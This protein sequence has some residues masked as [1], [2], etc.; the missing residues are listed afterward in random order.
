MFIPNRTQYML[1]VVNIQLFDC[2]FKMNNL[3]NL[4]EGLPISHIVYHLHNVGLKRTYEAIE[5]YKSVNRKRTDAKH[6]ELNIK[7]RYESTSTTK[8][9]YLTEEEI[10]ESREKGFII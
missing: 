4:S 10:N 5:L 8:K 1:A 6:Y 3:F 9:L 7:P 2:L